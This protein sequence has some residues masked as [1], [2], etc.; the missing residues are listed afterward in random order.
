MAEKKTP[1][2]IEKAPVKAKKEETVSV[3]IPRERKENEDDKVVWVNAKRYIIKKGER[4][5]V[6]ISV[7]K[8]LQHEEAMLDKQYEFYAANRK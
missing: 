2:N 6:P 1:E 3:Y 7:A 8:V 5:D 4:V